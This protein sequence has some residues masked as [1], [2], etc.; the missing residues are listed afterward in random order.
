MD[1]VDLVFHKDGVALAHHRQDAGQDLCLRAKG[2]PGLLQVLHGL[3]RQH[4]LGEEAGHAV[5]QL[6]HGA[7]QLHVK[8]A[9]IQVQR[10]EHGQG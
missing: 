4:R 8:V 6:F 1:A 9:G 3:L 10:A 7:A 2:L 5:F